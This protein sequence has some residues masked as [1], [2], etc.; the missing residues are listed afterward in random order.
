[1][2]RRRVILEYEIQKL[3]EYDDD[4]YTCLGSTTRVRRETPG[5]VLY[6]VYDW[7]LEVWFPR[8]VL[9]LEENGDFDM[10]WCG[11]QFFKKKERERL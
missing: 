1:M 10:I 9:R 11:T 5:A 2:I 8:N 6:H 4:E 7:D 3:A